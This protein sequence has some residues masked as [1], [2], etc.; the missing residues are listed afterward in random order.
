[1][2]RF[3]CNGQLN[4]RIKPSEDGRHPHTLVHVTLKHERKHVGYYDVSMPPEAVD[5]IR[6][7]L[8]VSPTEI[9]AK[10]TSAHPH[11]VPKQVYRFWT[12]LSVEL[13]QHDADPSKS[14]EILLDQHPD[15]DLW[16]LVVPEG[17]TAVA[18]GMKAIAE[19]IAGSVVEIAVDA[20]CQ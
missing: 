3:E 15:T 20:T 1:M 16:H 14:I 19:R 7:F 6:N 8:S 2:D 11:L 13:W 12:K 5:M 10:V 18:W 4:I 17:V 9:A